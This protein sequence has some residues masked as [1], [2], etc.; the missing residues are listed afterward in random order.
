MALKRLLH[1]LFNK[2]I[3]FWNRVLK[4]SSF[5]LI[6]NH[7]KKRHN[8]EMKR[9]KKI[10]FDTADHPTLLSQKQ[11]VLVVFGFQLQLNVTRFVLLSRQIL[12][13]SALN[14]PSWCQHEVENT[15]MN[16]HPKDYHSVHDWV[17]NQ[18]FPWSKPSSLRAFSAVLNGTGEEFSSRLLWPTVQY[19]TFLCAELDC[20]FITVK[21]PFIFGSKDN[22]PAFPYFS[23]FS[24][25]WRC[26]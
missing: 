19:I 12:R 3:H 17:R 4:K 23:S 22:F 26:K 10:I 15:Q 21:S 14:H 13:T 7:S 2:S 20:V 9:H 18:P 11:I 16:C 8:V 1:I 24:F 6:F 25:I 5:Y